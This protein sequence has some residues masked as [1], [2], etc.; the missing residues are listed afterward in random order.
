MGKERLI[1]VLS[2]VFYGLIAAVGLVFIA[3]SAV[4]LLTA[5]KEEPL[6]GLAVVLFI[7]ICFI[8]VVQLVLAVIPFAIR[9][10]FS[11]N[12]KI[13][14]I[15]ACIPFDVVFIASYVYAV[16]YSIIAES[17]VNFVGLSVGALLLLVSIATLVFNV[18]SIK[19][20]KNNTDAT[21]ADDIEAKEEE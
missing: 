7:V 3:I 18:I 4:L 6:Y 14:K 15:V 13:S 10:S 21:L 12:K 16:I 1:N 19:Y 5:S 9:L 8:G 11:K 2:V 20:L 17:S